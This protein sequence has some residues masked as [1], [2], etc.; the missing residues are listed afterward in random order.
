MRKLLNTIIIGCGLL[1]GT[2]AKSQ[3]LV[4]TV[5]PNKASDLY[6]GPVFSFSTIE[7][8]DDN[9]NTFKVERK[10][11]GLGINYKISQNVGLLFQ[12]GYTLKSKFIGANETY[13]G[14]G[15]MFGAGANFT[16]YRKGKV[17]F[18]GY[19]LLNYVSD[20]YKK[21]IFSMNVTDIHLGGILA[22]Q[23]NHAVTFYSG[24]DLI[25]YSG[26]TVK[27]QKSE[28]DIERSDMLSLKLG[29]DFTL[30]NVNIKPELTLLGEKTFTLSASFAL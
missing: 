11:I 26:G 4:D 17:A 15:Y 10:T 2:L 8:K 23:A 6:L 30:S 7:Y 1:Y 20:D 13:K 21:P 5:S 12:A 27:Y 14:K 19:G 29:L 18:L 3:I 16:M 9:D 22:I 25:A 28:V 24:V